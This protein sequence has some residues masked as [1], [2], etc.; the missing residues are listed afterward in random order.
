MLLWRP[1]CCG[2]ILHIK[3][4]WLQPCHLQRMTA[5]GSA[6]TSI[7]HPAITVCSD[8]Y[9]YS[10][11]AHGLVDWE[12]PKTKTNPERYTHTSRS[13]TLSLLAHGPTLQ[14]LTPA[15]ILFTHARKV[16]SPA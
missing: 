6:Q 8:N 2:F 15:H 1:C 5:F 14:A 10:S 9:G 11:H 4:A 7:W 3:D 13:Q 12:T 16:H